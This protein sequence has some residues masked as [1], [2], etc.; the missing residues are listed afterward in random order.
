MVDF[1]FNWKRALLSSTWSI[2]C[3]RRNVE[4]PISKIEI[5]NLRNITCRNFPSKSWR[6]IE[7]RRIEQIRSNRQIISGQN[8][9]PRPDSF[10]KRYSNAFLQSRRRIT[11]QNWATTTARPRNRRPNNIFWHSR[12]EKS[13]QTKKFPFHPRKRKRDASPLR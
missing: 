12:T 6:R 9:A 13:F 2:V 1:T 5:R 7:W 10:L 4:H 8:I 3:L 11:K